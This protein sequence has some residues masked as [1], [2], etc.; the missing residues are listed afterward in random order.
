MIILDYM[1]A[2]LAT[3]LAVL[4]IIFIPEIRNNITRLIIVIIFG[5]LSFVLGVLKINSNRAKDEY[6]AR[7]IDS[8]KTIITR[9][10]KRDSI[11]EKKI[12]SH[13][14]FLKRLDKIGVKDSANHPIIYNTKKFTNNIRDVGTLNE[15]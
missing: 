15:Y 10:N 11:L 14:V 1:L 3:L 9:I 4:G 2:F 5:I 6:D 7:K 8:L 12:D 13:T